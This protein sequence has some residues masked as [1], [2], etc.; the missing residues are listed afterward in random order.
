MKLQHL[1]KAIIPLLALLISS[2]PSPFTKQQ[3]EEV[4]PVAFVVLQANPIE[5]A[6]KT[7][8]FGGQ[9]ISVKNRKSDTEIEVLQKPLDSRYLPKDTDES[10]GRFLFVS[11]K[12]LDPA[13]YHRGRKITVI[14]I[15]RGAEQRLIGNLNYN[16]PLLEEVSHHLWMPGEKSPKVRVGV[17]MGFGVPIR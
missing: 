1:Y 17:G 9:I 5:Y 3:R 7:V 6:G 8:M 10:K 13:V 14:G 2:C 16:Y 15:V 4:L 11:H 12:Y